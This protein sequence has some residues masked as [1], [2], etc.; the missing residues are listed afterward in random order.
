MNDY[1]PIG[2]HGIVGDLQTVALVSSGEQST[3]GAR[4]DLIHQV[5]S[6]RCWTLSAAATV[7]SLRICRRTA[8]HR[9]GNSIYVGYGCPPDSLH[10]SPRS[11]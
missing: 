5:S 1:P 11:R 2:E 10:V 4:R 7:G 6:R 3:G 9:S 8:T